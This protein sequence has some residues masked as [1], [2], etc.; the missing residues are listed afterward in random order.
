MM[1]RRL[2]Q[3]VF[4]FAEGGAEVMAKKVSARRGVTRKRPSRRF[5][6]VAD[7]VSAFFLLND[8]RR[9][10]PEMRVLVALA[11]GEADTVELAD[12]LNMD[13][14]ATLDWL[15]M[16]ADDGLVL[17]CGLRR[18]NAKLWRIAPAGVVLL[19]DALEAFSGRRVRRR[20]SGR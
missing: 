9:V 18:G 16:A 19:K 6:E 2:I 5:L 3:G 10:L 4:G 11:T 8:G 7:C 12:R 14:R 1:M 20:R 15:N 17:E 13:T